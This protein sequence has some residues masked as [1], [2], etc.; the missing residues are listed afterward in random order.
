M[1][2]LDLRN[3]SKEELLL[4][5]KKVKEEL[6]LQK[7]ELISGKSKKVSDIREKRRDIARIQTV[8]KEKEVIEEL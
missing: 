1:K 2:A 5:L 4:D 7:T 6:V 3:K 8:L